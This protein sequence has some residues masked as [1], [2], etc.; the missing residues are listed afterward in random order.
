MGASCASETEYRQP[1]LHS[2]TCQQHKKLS[3]RRK[4]AQQ[5]QRK[6][7][8]QASHFKHARASIPIAGTPLQAYHFKHSNCCSLGHKSRLALYVLQI[9]M[10]DGA[11]FDASGSPGERHQRQARAIWRHTAHPGRSD[12]RLFSIVHL[13]CNMLLCAVL[14]Q[15]ELIV[16]FRGVVLSPYYHCL[17]MCS[18]SFDAAKAEHSIRFGPICM[19]SAMVMCQA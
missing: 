1:G 19:S 2:T 6:S 15:L 13:N 3:T 17:L 7:R 16:T 11:L 10:V 4:P 14:Q 18:K 12:A 5:L 8:W 9:S